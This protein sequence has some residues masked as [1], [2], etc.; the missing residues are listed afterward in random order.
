MKTSSMEAMTQWLPPK[1]WI[2]LYLINRLEF[3]DI[4]GDAKISVSRKLVERYYGKNNTKVAIYTLR[5]EGWILS[6]PD[7]TLVPGVEFV[8]AYM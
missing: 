3:A 2:I 1:Q 7:D 5:K 6:G 8:A 4:Y